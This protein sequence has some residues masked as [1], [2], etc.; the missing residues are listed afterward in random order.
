ML[1]PLPFSTFD[2]VRDLGHEASLFCSGC[3]RQVPIDLTDHRLAGKTFAGYR[4]PTC[5]VR[6]GI[7]WH[8]WETRPQ[9]V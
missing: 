7:H 2:Q 9:R 8:G 1:F 6:L 4:C 5:G 3:H